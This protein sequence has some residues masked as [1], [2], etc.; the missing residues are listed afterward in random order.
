VSSLVLSGPRFAWQPANRRRHCYLTSNG[1][2]ATPGTDVTA[3][4]ELQMTARRAT[5]EEWQWITC[6]ACD[7]AA[8]DLVAESR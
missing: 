8:H 2:P 5:V 6:P 7:Q 1:H 3:L 4:C